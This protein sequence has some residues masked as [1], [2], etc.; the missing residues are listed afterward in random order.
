MVKRVNNKAMENGDG[1]K[2][3]IPLIYFSIRDILSFN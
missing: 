3:L 2:N 1:N